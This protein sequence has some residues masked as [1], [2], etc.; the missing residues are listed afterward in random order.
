MFLSIN[1][2]RIKRNSGRLDDGVYPVIIEDSSSK[3]D[4]CV[5]WF[6]PSIIILGIGMPY[7]FSN[8]S[9]IFLNR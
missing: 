7:S 9:M 4:S 2:P 8:G 6:R 1:E 5:I 3:C